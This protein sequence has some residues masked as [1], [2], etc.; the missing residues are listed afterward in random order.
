M[1]SQKRRA[2]LSDALNE[3]DMRIHSTLGADEIMQ[4]AL[5]SFVEVLGADAGDIKLRDGDT[6]VVRFER[7]FGAAVVGERLTPHEAPVA[8]MVAQTGEPV[9]IQDYLTESR[10]EYVGFP[11]AHG[12]RATLAMPLVIRDEVAGCLFAWM[13]TEPRTFS[14]SEVDFARRM[15]ASVALALE[16]AR[17]LNAE[18]SARQRAEDAERLLKIELERTQVLLKAS[19]QLASTIELDELLERLAKIVLEAT[20]ISRVFVNLIDMESRT[21]TPGFATG[22]LAAPRGETIPFEALSETARGAIAGARTALLDYDRPQLPEQDRRIAVSNGARLV[23]FVP[24]VHLGEVIGH[25]SIDEPNERYDFVERQIR[26]V[27]AIAAQAAVAVSNAQLFAREHRIAETLQQ[28]ILSPPEPVDGVEIACLYQPASTVAAVGGDFYDV[29]DLGDGMV[30]LLIGDVS[31]KGLEAAR[32][33]SLVRDGARAYLQE[34]ADAG[35]VISRLNALVHRFTPVDKFTTAFLGILDRH[36]GTLQYSGGGQPCPVIMGARSTRM[37]ETAPGLLGA[38]S[39]APF[40]VHTTTLYPDE[41][42]VLVT[43]GITETRRDESLLGE[44]GLVEMLDS[45]RGVSVGE[46]PGALLRAIA[47]RSSGQLHD[48]VAIMCVK[49]DGGSDAQ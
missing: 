44:T 3:I 23:L 15:A 22:G 37:L 19:D 16:N 21:L 36:S 1:G 26:V 27:E 12:L 20:G 4:A 34:T 49:L 14:P 11:R 30:A 40:A 10:A 31:G 38:F 35:E 41:T 39:D 7:G 6:W 17:L 9:A 33:T 24:L 43:D 5:D 32:L 47:E 13:K 28:A 18:Q 8:T 45:F 42:L 48:D 46:L 25:I 2:Q 29:L